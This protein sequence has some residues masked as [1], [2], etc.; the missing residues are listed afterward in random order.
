M[1]KSIFR[2]VTA[3]VVSVGLFSLQCYALQCEDLFFAQATLK[4]PFGQ[5]LLRSLEFIDFPDI[6]VAIAASNTKPWARYEKSERYLGRKES[7]ETRWNRAISLDL[8][9]Q[10]IVLQMQE[11]QQVFSEGTTHSFREI[12]IDDAGGDIDRLGDGL[13]GF[14]R[15]TLSQA[16]ALEEN[17]LLL[18][19]VKP[20]PKGPG[21]V[22]ARYRYPT[23][24]T[25]NK[26]RQ[27]LSPELLGDLD[28]AD[29]AGQL[30]YNI[31]NRNSVGPIFRDL[32]KR[33]IAELL[34]A[35]FNP[36]QSA[37]TNYQRMIAIHPF[38]RS[39]S[40]GLVQSD[41]TTPNVFNRFLL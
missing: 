29:A 9:N 23:A 37:I 5:R 16:K 31:S 40:A 38:E 32:N 6:L 15:L 26:F 30:T 33:I 36:G 2:T 17:P 22:L 11:L 10:S 41:H 21:T 19:D 13:G 18:V 1:F 35:R 27:F 20:D 14:D 24:G 4:N 25:Y 3:L 39:N 28:K 7:L 8:K 34:Q 12:P